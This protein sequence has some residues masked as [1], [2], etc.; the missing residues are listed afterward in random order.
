MVNR[1]GGCVVM[2]DGREGDGGLTHG[3]CV[4]V[5]E[6]MVVT[7]LIEVCGSDG[8]DLVTM[9]GRGSFMRARRRFTL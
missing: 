2:K 6:V 4:R 3:S 1:A 5:K 7:I 8:E 9:S